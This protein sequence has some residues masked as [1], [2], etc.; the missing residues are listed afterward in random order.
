MT[1]PRPA[2]LDPIPPIARASA[3]GPAG[4][5][6]LAASVAVAV[7]LIA[8]GRDDG[9]PDDAVS[10]GIALA[11]RCDASFDAPAADGAGSD[12]AGAGSATDGSG[13][14]V[15]TDR[16]AACIDGQLRRFPADPVA[17]AGLHFHA[18][19]IAERAVA[20][21]TGRARARARALRD[22]HLLAVSKALNGNLLS[23]HRLCAAAAANCGPIA[24]RLARH[25]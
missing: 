8:P 12:P 3:H 22:R 4:L 5:L 10:E 24:E 1:I 14:L 19:Q 9:R 16:W 25:V 6:V 11:A 20:S 21:G 15:G 2:P 18:W 13:T 17:V 23:L 7:A